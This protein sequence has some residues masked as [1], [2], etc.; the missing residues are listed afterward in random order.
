MKCFR[1][2]AVSKYGRSMHVTL[3][4][5]DRSYEIEELLPS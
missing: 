1:N 3:L 5:G 4:A 2:G